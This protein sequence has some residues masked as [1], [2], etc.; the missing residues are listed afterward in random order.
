MGSSIDLDFTTWHIFRKKHEIYSKVSQDVHVLLSDILNF[1]A[2]KLYFAFWVIQPLLLIRLSLIAC[3]FRHCPVSGHWTQ[4]LLIHVSVFLNL[5]CLFWT[6][7]NVNK[8]LLVMKCFGSSCQTILNILNI[9]ETLKHNKEIYWTLL[10]YMTDFYFWKTQTFFL[11]KESV[12]QLRTKFNPD[13]LR[14]NYVKTC[15]FSNHKFYR[16]NE[17]INNLHESTNFHK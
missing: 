9:P 6:E 3:A 8:T 13:R 17:C 2:S 10:K 14:A 11:S 4:N 7:R 1:A 12:T 5:P 16:R 15:F